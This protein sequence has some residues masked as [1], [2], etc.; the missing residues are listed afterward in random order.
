MAARGQVF[1]SKWQIE[2]RLF[3]RFDRVI[4]RWPYVKPHAMVIYDPRDYN[5]RQQVFEL[6]GALFGDSETLLEQCRTFHKGVEDFRQRPRDAHFLLH[7]YLR[8]TATVIFHFL[9]RISFLK[10]QRQPS[11]NLQRQC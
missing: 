6:E 3:S 10:T 2:R 8:T 5:V 4:A 9:A 11:A 1:I 7:T